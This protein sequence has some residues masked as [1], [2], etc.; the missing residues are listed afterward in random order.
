MYVGNTLGKLRTLKD[1]VFGAEMVQIAPDFCTCLSFLVD[2]TT[3][4]THMILSH[5]HPVLVLPY[6]EDV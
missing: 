1:G 6:A 3:H 2:K 4:R 5:Q